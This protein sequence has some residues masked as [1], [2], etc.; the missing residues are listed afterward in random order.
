MALLEGIRALKE[1]AAI[2]ALASGRWHSVGGSQSRRWLWP[3]PGEMDLVEEAGALPESIFAKRIRRLRVNNVYRTSLGSAA[4]MPFRSPVVATGWPEGVVGVLSDVDGAGNDVT[5][6]GRMAATAKMFA[7][8]HFGLVEVSETADAIH[9]SHVPAE[10]LRLWR[11]EH[12]DGRIRLL[13]ANVETIASAQSSLDLPEDPNDYEP[14]AAR[15]SIFVYRAGIDSGENYAVM[16]YDQ[17]SSGKY[18]PFWQEPKRPGRGGTRDIPLVPFYSSWGQPYRSPPR[19]EDAAHVQMEM[20]RQQ[21]ELDDMMRRAKQPLNVFS[22]VIPESKDKGCVDD[23]RAV[24]LHDP[25]ARA[26]LVQLDAGAIEVL[27]SEVERGETQVRMACLDPM[28]LQPTGSA[29]A[30]EIGVREIRAST[31]LEASAKSD[32]A[33]LTQLAAY[34]AQLLGL[35]SSSSEGSVQLSAG[36]LEV[37]GSQGK[38]AELLRNLHAD[39]LLSRRTTLN[40]LQGLE[41]GLPEDLD[42]EEEAKAIAEDRSNG[43]ASS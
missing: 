40:S 15:R 16:R 39:G 25:D 2:D 36:V 21:S 42:P 27:A 13:Q 20:I 34:T 5:S 26:S 14:A 31:W 30:T 22:G 38:T 37:F 11:W 18:E 9:W 12:E 17:T 1:D 3:N 7:G 24:F 10:A 28:V 6:F 29:T 4:A 41:V 35:E 19:F 8:I 32:Q 43:A 33:S 23:G